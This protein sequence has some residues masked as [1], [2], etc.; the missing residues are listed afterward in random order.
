MNKGQLKKGGISTFLIFLLITAGFISVLIF[1]GIF[2]EGS[3]TGATIIV[4]CYGTGDYDSIQ[5]AVDASIPGDTIFVWD[6]S[7][8]ENIY[9]DKSITLIGNGSANT[10]IIGESRLPVVQ[11][12][13]YSVNVN[14]FSIKSN[15]IADGIV[16]SGVS[17]CN[18]SNNNCSN[19][20][21][22]IHMKNSVNNIIFNNI[23]MDCENGII[24]EKSDSNKIWNNQMSGCG[25]AIFGDSLTQWNTHDIANNNTVNGKPIYYW[26]NT[27]SGTIPAGAGQVLLANCQNINVKYQNL[28]Y[29]C[30]GVQLG[31]S[32][33]NSVEN[34]LCNQNSKFGIYLYK[35]DMNVIANNSCNF[36][37]W[38]GIELIESDI[39]TIINNTCSNNNDGI[40]IFSSNSNTII[41]NTCNSNTYD[42]IW[43]AGSS[44][45]IIDNNTLNSNVDDGIDIF[46]SGPNYVANNTCSLNQDHGI[47]LHYSKSATITNNNMISCGLHL[48]GYLTSQYDSHQIDITNTVNSKPVYYWKNINA[49]TIPAGAGEVLLISCTN[50]IIENQDLSNGSS[51]IELFFSDNNEIKNNVLNQNNNNG[52][53]L[54]RS[55]QNEINNNEFYL[56]N[57]HGILLSESHSN[58]II[59]NECNYNI[60]QGIY[61]KYSRYNIIT[62]NICNLNNANGII[63]KNSRNNA[64]TFNICNS[65]L[66]YGQ[67]FEKSNSNDILNNTCNSNNYDGIWLGESDLNTISNN[68]C[69][70][71][72]YGQNIF[73]SNSNE[74]SNNTCNSNSDN[75]ILLSDSNSNTIVDNICLNNDY[76]LK[77]S[78]SRLNKIQNNNYSL[79]HIVGI[80]LDNSEINSINDNTCELNPLVS[81]ELAYSDWN[82]IENNSCNQ[83]DVSIYLYKSHSNVIKN[84]DCSLNDFYGIYLKDSSS[85]T[86]FH[87]L[88]NNNE[89]GIDLTRSS[90]NIVQNNN[91]TENWKGIFIYLGSSNNLFIENTISKNSNL[92]ISVRT[93]CNENRFFYNSFIDNAKQAEEENIGYNYWDNGNYEG[94]Y[95]SDYTGSDNGAKGRVL[96]DGIGDTE[97]PHLG[98]DNYPFTNQSGWLYPAKPILIVNNTLDPDG[99]FLLW[100]NETRGTTGYILEEDDTNVFDSPMTF[101]QGWTAEDGYLI[102]NVFNKPEGT[103]YYRLKAFNEQFE[104]NWSDIVHITVDFPPIIPQNLLVSVYPAGNTLNITWDSNPVDTSEYELYFKNETISEWEILDSI[105]H[106]I[107]IY[108]HTN[109]SD[110]DE[111]FYKIRSKDSV[112]QYSDFSNIVSGIPADTLPPRIPTG[113]H[114]AKATNESITII[115]D[116]NADADLVGYKIYK[117]TIPHSSAW[118]NPINSTM[119]GDEKYID[120][121]MEN[122]TRY[123]Y[124]VTAFD[125]V[126][127]ESNY[128]QV[129][130]GIINPEPQA[131][132]INHSIADFEIAEDTIDSTSINLFYWFIDVNKDP[133]EFRCFG[134]EHI[135]VTIY[136]ENGTVILIPEKDWNGQETLTFY[137]NDSTSEIFDDVTITVTPVN[138]P[139]G[140]INIFTPKD[141]GVF[142]LG[143][144]INFSAQCFDPDMIYGDE[145][146]FNWSS[147]ISGEFGNNKILVNVFLPIGNHSISL[148]VS[149]IVGETSKAVVNI[150][151]LE[152]PTPAKNDKDEAGDNMLLIG[153]SISIIVIILIILL[154]M[155]PGFLYPGWGKLKE[156]I[157]KPKDD[158]SE[159][160]TTTE[161]DAKTEQLDK[162]STL[163]QLK[164]SN[165]KVKKSRSQVS[166]KESVKHKLQKPEKN[167]KKSSLKK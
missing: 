92:G 66:Y 76:G 68:T 114:I 134:Q 25:L 22:G 158:A 130:M 139:P 129:L 37:S 159:S 131:P 32:N 149:D 50:I 6:G 11:I 164:K 88:C 96:G 108:N 72:N 8:F 118:G 90:Q 38:D 107:N 61:L 87:N 135:N 156:K 33:N 102:F 60:N 100:W 34:N 147:N 86:V 150:T 77:L 155:F 16:L 141:G 101:N 78:H 23:F 26:K 157:W 166:T 126:P 79:N 104:S 146:T 128:S 56:N 83:T 111:Y 153:A 35:S 45:N 162:K 29:T 69:N 109:L 15:Q 52:I 119:I 10:V 121:E 103:Y 125:E 81:I 57:Y 46:E 53:Y 117:S 142:D 115:W 165:K 167:S 163:E 91:I 59:N 160:D 151:I 1:N 123:Y 42:G 40:N 9:M 148:I 51:G 133:L 24:I 70:S 75:G 20:L 64:I 58:T 73:A 28:D 97:I 67:Y 154:F 94:N 152:I 18:I 7:Y 63:L 65:N 17:N 89:Y 19:N 84:N 161:P 14:G 30:I 13:A 21:I 106:P 85:N 95:W 5:A 43:A 99:D 71:N 62:H 74:I 112:G 12:T 31:Y 124:V 48:I 36:V 54:W 122:N 138:D 4:D 80:K 127:N 2:D 140:F 143:T 116:Q 105:Q 110:G 145:L 82:F 44:S 132:E 41:N 113:L 136:Q 47:V 93:G 39:N 55:D 98:L 49:G 3:V 27:N 120:T 137:A 144:P